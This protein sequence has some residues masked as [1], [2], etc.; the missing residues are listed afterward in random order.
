MGILRGALTARRYTVQGEAP[1]GFRITYVEALNAYGYRD[2]GSKTSKEET[3]GWV[4]PQNLLYADFDDLNHWL[5]GHYALFGLRVDKK[6][7]PAALFR[8]HLDRAVSEWSEQSGQKVAPRGVKAEL[9]ERL[10]FE[11]LQRA[12]PRVRVTEVC[13]NM[14]EGTVLFANLSDRENDRFRKLFPQTFGLRLQPTNPLDWLGD[15]DLILALEQT[16]GSNLEV[17]HG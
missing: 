15:E 13:W 1:E 16:G 4:R 17:R 2:P 3:W 10:E 11:W 9:K 5:F 7:L 12:I 14:A 8:A 6:V